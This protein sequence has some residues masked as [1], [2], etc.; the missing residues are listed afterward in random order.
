M[1]IRHK[2]TGEVEEVEPTMT[3]PGYGWC[4]AGP[5]DVDRY[6]PKAYWEP[7]PEEVWE[8]CTAECVIEDDEVCHHEGNGHSGLCHYLLDL[9]SMQQYGY[10][11]RKVTYPDGMH[12]KTAFIIE[13]KRPA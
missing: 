12:A 6:Y 7:V 10:R 8:D 11:L 1:K 3:V 4:K 9:E 2:Q 5:L 13:R